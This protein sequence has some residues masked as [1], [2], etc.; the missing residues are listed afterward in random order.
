M[1]PAVLTKRMTTEEMLALPEDGTTHWLIEGRLRGKPKVFPTTA[2]DAGTMAKL[3]G[4]LGT[5]VHQRP[6]PRGQV[7]GGNAGIIL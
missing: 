7:V 1:A 2:F 3:G 5:F 6:R 4:I